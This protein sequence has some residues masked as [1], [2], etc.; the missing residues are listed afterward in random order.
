MTGY[1]TE[2]ILGE[3]DLPDSY[4][5]L[6][7]GIFWVTVPQRLI[8]TEI[9]FIS[10]KLSQFASKA[11]SVQPFGCDPTASKRKNALILTHNINLVIST[12]R[13]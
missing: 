6:I 13:L 12:H 11:P 7:T 1:Q 3:R 10:V 8:V 5:R 2:K 4:V 9:V